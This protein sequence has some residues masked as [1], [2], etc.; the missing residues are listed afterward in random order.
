MP[1]IEYTVLHG[2]RK[3]LKDIGNGTYAE[4][5][6][7]AG[8]NFNNKL[9]EAF[10]TFDYSSPNAPWQLTLAPGDIVQ[11]DG[12]TAGAS[13]LVIS[14]S[15]LDVGETRVEGR[16]SFPVP[17]KWPGACTARRPPSGKRLRWSW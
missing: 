3:K 1:D 2:V 16:L 12:N 9:R 15:P 11:V 8:T 6:A 13:Y 5:T 7:P 4:V 14:K 17:W 10:E